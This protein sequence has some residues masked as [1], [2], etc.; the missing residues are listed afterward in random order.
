MYDTGQ[1]YGTEEFC[2]TSFGSLGDLNG[3]ETLN[4]LDI[5]LMVDMIFEG[6]V[7]NYQTA[8]INGDNEISI[9]DI[10][11]LINMVLDN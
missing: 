9:L 7:P 8:D 4:I 11:L 5:V 1:S 3:D 10:I 6:S 2:V